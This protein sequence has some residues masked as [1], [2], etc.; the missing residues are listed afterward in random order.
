MLFRSVMTYLLLFHWFL[1]YSRECA[2][3]FI[4][5]LAKHL[6]W[7]Y[8]CGWVWHYS[9]GQ[10]PGPF[11]IIRFCWKNI[12]K[13]ANRPQITKKRTKNDKDIESLHNYW[14][15][16]FRKSNLMNS[17]KTIAI[18]K[19]KEPI[20]S[21]VFGKDISASFIFFSFLF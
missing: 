3:S 7:S 2:E 18:I 19:F 6:R 5:Y 11:K 1:S 10:F 8:F 13:E 21:S 12:H 15:W 17:L 16:L 9:S 20:K 4:Y 14:D